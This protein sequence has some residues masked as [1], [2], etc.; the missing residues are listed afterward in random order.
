M[1]QI[2]VDLTSRFL[3]FLPESNRRPQNLQSRALTRWD[4][5]VS[6][7]NIYVR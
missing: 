3:E 7:V 2:H 1:A 4:S 6:D 5:F